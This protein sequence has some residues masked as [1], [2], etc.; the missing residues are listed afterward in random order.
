MITFSEQDRFP[1]YHI[2]I[3][4]GILAPAV[5]VR[6]YFMLAAGEV[7]ANLLIFCQKSLVI[8]IKI[9]WKL[10]FHTLFASKR[11]HHNAYI[12]STQIQNDSCTSRRKTLYCFFN[13]RRLKNSKGNDEKRSMSIP[14]HFLS[15]KPHIPTANQSRWA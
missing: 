12:W 5:F 8:P 3:L 7:G 1:F 15:S 6:L 2:G 14:H 11:L 13:S 9:I 4:H 10:I